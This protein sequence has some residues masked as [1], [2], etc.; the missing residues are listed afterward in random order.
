MLTGKKYIIFDL[1]GTLIDSVGI[2]NKVD[3]RFIAALGGN[4]DGIDVQ[5]QRDSKLR[6][7]KAEPDPY[8]A[9]C[10]YLGEQ[11][12]SSLSPDELV[13]LRYNIAHAL[14]EKEVDYK[15]YADVLLH[16][17]YDRG[18]TLIIASTTRKDNLDVY[19]TKNAKM[20]SKAN[21]EELFSAIYTREDAKEIKPS[22]EIY[23][24]ILREFGATPAECL[25]FEDSLI[26]VEAA[27]NAGIDVIA[28]Y[29]EYSK[30]DAEEIK[31]RSVA[32]FNNHK[33]LLREII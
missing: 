15:P 22:P 24:R 4:S 12:S 18:Y 5:A 28:V 25:V 2:W 17:L 9:Y 8:K 3:H 10:K 30:N 32:Y 26:G 11:Y 19:R 16:K 7:Y 14:T 6:E 33:E 21:L 27:N 20:I 13:K 1:D 29:D 23:E 31:R